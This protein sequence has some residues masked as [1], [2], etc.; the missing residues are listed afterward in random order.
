MVQT[1]INKDFLPKDPKMLPSEGQE[2]AT[3]FSWA[4]MM[5][6]RYPE[7]RLMFHVPNGGG[8]SKAEAGRFKMEGVKAGVPDIFLPV[9]RGNF[10]GM[11]VEMKKRKGGKVSAEQ[12]VWI[13]ELNAQ[14]YYAVVACGWDEASSCIIDYLD[15]GKAK[16]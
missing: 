9:P 7:L 5:E 3:L 16:A 8:R 14:G 10:H 2:Q 15:I 13:S 12:K 4:R 6:G 11:F 1:T